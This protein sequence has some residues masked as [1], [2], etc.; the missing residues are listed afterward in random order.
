MKLFCAGVGVNHPDV[1]NAS[2]AIKPKEKALCE[3]NGV[4]EIIEIVAVSY[5]HLTLPTNLC[6]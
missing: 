2:R 3:K 4:A 6:V 1:T 5:T